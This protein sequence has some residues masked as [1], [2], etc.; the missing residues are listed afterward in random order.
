MMG[1]VEDNCDR[2]GP[3]RTGKRPSEW[4][5]RLICHLPQRNLPVAYRPPNKYVLQV[6]T[7]CPRRNSIKLSRSYKPS[8]RMVLSDPLRMISST[9]AP[10]FFYFGPAGTL[11]R[12]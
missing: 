12:G 11:S 3:W 7:P 6:E 9:C 2:A 1:D 4:D 10:P 8:P 5:A